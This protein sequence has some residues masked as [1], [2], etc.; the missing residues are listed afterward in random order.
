MHYLRQWRD[1]RKERDNAS[2]RER[3]LVDEDYRNR[4]NARQRAKRCEWFY[5]MTFDQKLQRLA[6]QGGTCAICETS[7]PGKKG[8]CTDHD[9]L[10]FQIRGE[11]CSRCNCR[12]GLCD[13]RPDLLSEK[14]RRYLDWYQALPDKQYLPPNS[15]KRT[16]AGVLDA[17]SHSGP[18][19][20]AGRI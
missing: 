13:E 7:T 4:R 19:L 8:W 9:H 12:L 16:S 11:L 2:F 10:T 1:P 20:E 3:L 18:L 14:E 15:P 6:E 5:G 17:A